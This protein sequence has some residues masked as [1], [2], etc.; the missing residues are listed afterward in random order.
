[1]YQMVVPNESA[2]TLNFEGE[3]IGEALSCLDS[4]DRLYGGSDCRWSE[5]RLYRSADGQYICEQV[6]SSHWKA[7]NQRHKVAVCASKAQ[8]VA[9]FGQ[10]WLARELYADADIY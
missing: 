2:K 6:R 10:D 1:M 4:P 8:I 5:L 9:F 7:A 3:M